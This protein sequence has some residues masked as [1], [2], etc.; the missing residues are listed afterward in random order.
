VA[1]D[2]TITARFSEGVVGLSTASFTLTDLKTHKL[3]G[4]VVAYD[5]ATR[6]ATLTPK[7][8]LAGSASFRVS[9][10]SA[11]AD[12]AGNALVPVAWSFTTSADT[13]PPKVTNRQPAPRSTGVNLFPAISATFS[14]QVRP[15]N[16]QSFIVVEVSTGQLVRGE[17]SYDPSR[18]TATFGSLGGLQRNAVYQVTLTSGIT[19]VAGNSLTKTSWTFTTGSD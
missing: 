17:I 16:L 10:G 7:A 8:H 15:P 14:E 18:L 6:T 4:A 9:L 11:I 3:L 19:D 2:I 13:T 1:R 5:P 12:S